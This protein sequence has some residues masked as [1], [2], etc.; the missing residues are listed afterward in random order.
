MRRNVKKLHWV[1]WFVILTFVVFYV[2][3]FLEGPPNVVAR[4]DGDP[5]YIDEYQRALQQQ[6]AY[7]QSVSGGSLPDDFLRQIQLEEIVLETLIRRKLIIAAA[8]DEGLTVAKREVQQRIRTHPNLLVDGVFIGIDRYRQTLRANGIDIEEFEQEIANDL[9]FEKFTE[10]ASNGVAIAGREIEDE[11]QRRNEQVRFDFFVIRPTGFETEVAA[12]VTDEAARALFADTVGDYR[13]PEQRR[14]SYTV[15]ETEAVRDSVELA[16]DELQ[17]AYEESVGEFTVPEQVRA[18]HILF[19]L[20]PDPDEETLS[21]TRAVAQEILDQ[22]RGGADFA[23][24]AE[25]NSDDTVTATAGGDLGWFGRG[26]MAPEFEEA[27]FALEVDEVS[28]LVQTPFGLHILRLD[29]H[30]PEQVRPFDEVRGQL[31]QQLASERAETIAEQRAED[32]RVAVLR[33]AGLEEVA[34]EFGLEVAESPLFT[35]AAGFAEVLSPEFTRQV[36]ATGRGRVSEPIRFGRGYVVFRVD[37][38]VEAHDPSFE[39]VEDQVRRDLIVQL[40]QQ[41]AAA[42]ARELGERL[43][44]SEPFAILAEEVGASIQ[45]TELIPRNGV[46]PVLGRQTALVLAAFDLSEGEAGGPVRV[47][48]GHALL[49]VTSHLQPDWGQYAEQQEVLRAELLNQRRSSLFESLVR[50]LRE[51][52]RVVTYEDVWRSVTS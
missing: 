10:L 29:G 7:Y 3:S 45:T 51:H 42:V 38:I 46:V 17:A 18:R 49:R 35:Q 43:A 52:Y 28:D 33:R 44:Q 47:D 21:S 36:F 40:A 37:E 13:V 26:R 6:T 25:A 15:V 14:V 9:L 30:R 34:E 11:Y 23:A 5:I 22:I 19:R 27:A 1:L 24:L 16:D 39:E 2:P 8:R 48:R 20:P 4:V 31:E 41:R 32:V 12:D 50:Q